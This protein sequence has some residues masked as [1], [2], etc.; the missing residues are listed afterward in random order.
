MGIDWT[1]VIDEARLRVDEG[2]NYIRKWRTIRGLVGR[3]RISYSERVELAARL[4]EAGLSIVP[5]IDGKT[6]PMGAYMTIRGSDD[7]APLEFVNERTYQSWVAANLSKLA[8]LRG[9]DLVGTEVVVRGGR[10]D[11]VALKHIDG[12]AR[13]WYIIEVKLTDIDGA[14]NQVIAYARAFRETGGWSKS[15]GAGAAVKTVRPSPGDQITVVVVAHEHSD[16]HEASMQAGAK[17]AG[18]YAKW[19]PYRLN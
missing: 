14:A 5:A 9:L 11:L 17:V 18:F 10:I 16:V 15:I 6:P 2:R 8:P 12:G 13:R 4:D 1:P 19:V 3:T 7:D